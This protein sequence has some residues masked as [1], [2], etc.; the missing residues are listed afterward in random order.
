M[1]GPSSLTASKLPSSGIEGDVWMK[2][3]SSL[4][5][6]TSAGGSTTEARVRQGTSLTKSTPPPTA[7]GSS[8]ISNTLSSAKGPAADGSRSAS[9]LAD[10]V[11]RELFG[12]PDPPAAPRE[13]SRQVGHDDGV[14]SKTVQLG[15]QV[16]KPAPPGAFPDPHIPY[17]YPPHQNW[18]SASH[19]Q[20]WQPPSMS[21]DKNLPSATSPAPFDPSNGL[22]MYP[23][24]GHGY[25]AQTGHPPFNPHHP[26]AFMYNPPPGQSTYNPSYQNGFPYFHPPP[27]PPPQGARH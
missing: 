15:G 4:A 5:T 17:S 18:Y 10:Q 3:S 27:P 8:A 25:N 7:D 14:P 16:S 2:G 21:T 23:P 13:S 12:S 9:A 6:R 24:G 22:P 11:A 19:M 1:K 20:G 26:P